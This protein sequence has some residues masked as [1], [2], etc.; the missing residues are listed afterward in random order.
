MCFPFIMSTN[1]NCIMLQQNISFMYTCSI[2]ICIS[3]YSSRCCLFAACRKNVVLSHYVSCLWCMLTNKLCISEKYIHNSN[4]FTLLCAKNP[5]YFHFSA[6]LSY[7][8]L[9]FC[10]LYIM[11][12]CGILFKR[13][14]GVIISWAVNWL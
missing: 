9:Y 3:K 10:M 1:E 8:L 6:F 11:F 5:F 14:K 12:L 4:F 7:V 13:G 2:Y